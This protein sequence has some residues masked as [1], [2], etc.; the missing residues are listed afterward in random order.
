M[1]FRV[2]IIKDRQTR[3]SKGVAFILFLSK[4]D[5]LRAIEAFNGKEVYRAYFPDE[6]KKFIYCS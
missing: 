1:L 4:E 3:Q 2:T 6:S 5:A